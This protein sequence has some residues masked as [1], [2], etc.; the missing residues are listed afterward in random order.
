MLHRSASVSRNPYLAIYPGDMALVLLQ[1]SSK[2]YSTPGDRMSYEILRGVPQFFHAMVEY[3]LDT[4]HDSF[5]R[6]S[7]KS[8]IYL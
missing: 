7:F 3:Y 8:S 2:F 4:G 6:H 5:L 1:E